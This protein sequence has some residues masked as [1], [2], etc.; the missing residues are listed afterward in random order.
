MSGRRLAGRPACGRIGPRIYLEAALAWHPTSSSRT[1]EY[2]VVGTRPIRHDGYDKVTGK[3]Q[4]GADVGLPGMLHGKVLRSPHA[5]A[6]IV[7]I[8]T[9]R[10]EAHPD[11]E[12]VATSAD[13]ADAGGDLAE[14]A[15]QRQDTGRRQGAVQGPP[16]RGGGR[17]QPSRSGRSAGAHR[18]RVR[19]A[20]GP[21]PTSIRPRP[22]ARRCSTTSTRATSRATTS[23]P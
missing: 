9:S 21:S 11:V 5:H 17:K 23:C 20:G 15:G 3:A 19:G 8:D 1:K 13:L 18:R 16:H 22:M 4:Y 7:S 6:R 2:K 12:A 10:A 14:A